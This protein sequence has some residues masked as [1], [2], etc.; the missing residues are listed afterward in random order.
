MW[1]RLRRFRSL[2]SSAQGLFV[3]SVVVLRLTQFSL[4]LRGF[5]ATEITLRKLVRSSKS[6]PLV[7]AFPADTASAKIAVTERM[8]QAAARHGFGHPTC[9]EK[10]LTL[11][12][13]LAR[14][15][16][17]CNLRIGTRKIKEKF[18]AHAWLEYEG[19]ALSD[20]EELHR[21]YVAFEHEFS[22]L[23]PETR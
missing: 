16:I 15:G 18:E 1:E 13:L 3:R 22:S 2:D 23:P 4:R 19:V 11:W 9:L 12:W 20:P 21:H 5:R 17:S 8:V 10:S 7:R 6:D 14:E